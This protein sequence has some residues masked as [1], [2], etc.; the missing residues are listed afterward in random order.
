MKNKVVYPGTFDPITN[1]HIDIIKRA[2]EMFEDVT[3]AVSEGAHKNPLFSWNERINM[4]KRAVKGMDNVKVG[5][6]RGMLVNYMKSIKKRIVIRGLR[7]IADF[8][9][10]FQLCLLNKKMGSNIEMVY[11]M[12]GEQ[13]LYISSSA[14]KEIA[15][16][17]GNA[18]KFVP[19]FVNKLLKQKAKSSVK[20]AKK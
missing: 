9:Y 17:G 4:V 19:G 12:P 11:L 1:G 8:E 18:E 3:V 10:E 20:K 14:V 6:Y 16:Y 2:G 5:C 15:Y 7:A 13:Y